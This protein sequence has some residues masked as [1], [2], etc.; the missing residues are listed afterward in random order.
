MLRRNQR[1]ED[2]DYWDF[3]FSG[4]KTAVVEL[5]RGLEEAGTL[6]EEVPHVAAAFQ[7]AAVDV[8]A[9][10][11]LRAVEH[12]GCPRVVLGGGVSANG[13]LREVFAE[14][15][16][17]DGR[18]FHASPRLSLDNGA[19]VARAARFRWKVGHAASENASASASLAFPGMTAGAA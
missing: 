11:T 3:S 16:G 5:V 7:E 12:T 13:R 1:I 14:R 19:M 18:L 17:G 4:L 10:K 9:T 15:L 2:A 6:A 8:L